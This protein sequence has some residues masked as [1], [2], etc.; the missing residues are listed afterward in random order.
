MGRLAECIERIKED[1]GLDPQL[2]GLA[3][4]SAALQDLDIPPERTLKQSVEKILIEL[5]VQLDLWAGAAEVTAATTIQRQN[6]GWLTRNKE[7]PAAKRKEAARRHI[8]QELRSTEITYNA[9]LSTLIEHK[10]QLVA[11]AEMAGADNDEARLSRAWL[12]KSMG[13]DGA[14]ATVE[15]MPSSEDIAKIFSNVHELKPISDKLLR[16]LDA[17]VG[18]GG[19]AWQPGSRVCDVLT[20]LAPQ[21]DSYRYYSSKYADATAHLAKCKATFPQ[22]AAEL[23]AMTGNDPNRLSLD[24][25]LI[26]PIQRLPRYMLLLA[27]LRKYSDAAHADYSHLIEAVSAVGTVAAGVD[28]YMKAKEAAIS[29]DPETAMMEYS[30]ALASRPHDAGM[31]LNRAICCL[32]I[33]E[34]PLLEAA[35]V[36]L[37]IVTTL[38][39]NQFKSFSVQGE[40]LL[41]LGR[42]AEAKVAFTTALSKEPMRPELSAGL[43]RAHAALLQQQQSQSQLPENGQETEGQSQQLP[44]GIP[45]A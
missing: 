24:S 42:P 18:E 15:G 3:A 28:A 8:V 35:L 44:E 19:R 26:T 27:E 12:A 22:L 32:K 38:K 45:E 41:A 40:C 30:K 2:R 9:A 6:R 25:Y 20:Q 17:R 33:G 1:L 4:V 5:G 21:L 31:L 43:Q 13:G 39:P 7:L 16:E 29:D 36:D 14:T 34:A 10:E 23:D 37:E 11:H